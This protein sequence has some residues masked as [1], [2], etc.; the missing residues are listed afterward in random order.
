MKILYSCSQIHILTIHIY[1]YGYNYICVYMIYICVRVCNYVL[2]G[3]PMVLWQ[4]RVIGM[5]NILYMS[6]VIGTGV[7]LII[8]P[9]IRI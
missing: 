4:S 6:W 7:S 9:R 5:D 1:V 3:I 2:A 8:N